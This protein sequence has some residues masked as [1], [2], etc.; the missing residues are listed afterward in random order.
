MASVS[1]MYVPSDSHDPEQRQS[2]T[3]EGSSVIPQL[4]ALVQSGP[5]KSVRVLHIKNRKASS[6]DFETPLV[7][8]IKK[9]AEVFQELHLTNCAIDVDKLKT[10]FRVSKSLTSLGIQNNNW[11]DERT[12]GWLK[13]LPRLK[14]LDIRGSFPQIWRSSNRR[15]L[16]DAIISHPTLEN[17]HLSEFYLPRLVVGKLHLFDLTLFR[18]EEKIR[19]AGK[20]CV[21][22]PTSM[23]KHII[24][25]SVAVCSLFLF[26][27]SWCRARLFP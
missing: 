21:I 7:E 24:A 18:T 26:S 11:L 6:E 4:K 14:T 3:L 9:Q 2:I 20:V 12:F 19:K 10:I 17:V 13:E 8:F 22:H 25:A 1:L 27:S 23:R 15:S 5:E 16:R